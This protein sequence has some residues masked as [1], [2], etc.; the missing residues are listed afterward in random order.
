MRHPTVDTK[1]MPTVFRI[2]PMHLSDTDGS[3][4]RTAANPLDM[5]IPWSASPMAE[6]SSVK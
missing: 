6:S 4:A 2:V 1:V 3:F 5:L